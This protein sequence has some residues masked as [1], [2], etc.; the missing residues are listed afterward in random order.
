MGN[1]VSQQ[2]EKRK[3]RRAQTLAPP[4]KPSHRFS[5][6]TLAA[7][8]GLSKRS[9]QQTS[10]VA[11]SPP[12]T[13]VA[14]PEPEPQLEPEQVSKPPTPPPP[15]PEKESIP[16]SVIEVR[17]DLVCSTAASKSHLLPIP[18]S[19][20]CSFHRTTRIR[21]LTLKEQSCRLNL[22]PFL[23]RYVLEFCRPQLSSRK[24]GIICSSSHALS[25]FLLFSF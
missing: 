6:S 12:P 13:I 14:V 23:V 2:A 20:P 9:Q 19:T 25:L 24:E 22:L 10:S 18:P 11:S 17:F 1:N 4:Q 7:S 15:P 3:S 21:T 16:E 8:V 5:T